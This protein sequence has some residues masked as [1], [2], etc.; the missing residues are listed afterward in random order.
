VAKA[1]GFIFLLAAGMAAIVLHSRL[2]IPMHLPGKQGV[3]FMAL[4]LSARGLYNKPYSA[5]ISCLGSAGLLLVPGLG[6]HDPFMAVSYLLLG[7]LMDVVYAWLSKVTPRAWVVTGIT[8]LC[9]VIIPAFRLILSC[10]VTMPMGSFRSGILFPFLTHMAFGLAGGLA[11][12]A[13]LGLTGLAR[14]KN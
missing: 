7:G 1:A 3:L 13:I 5:S 8:G 9:W 12:A 2:R 6:F 10:F 4:I 11:A 14:A